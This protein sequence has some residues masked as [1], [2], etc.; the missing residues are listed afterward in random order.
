MIPE[1]RRS[2]VKLAVCAAVLGSIALVTRTA[3]AS[4][5]TPSVAESATPHLTEGVVELHGTPSDI[6]LALTD[7]RSW[8]QLF[9]DVA[10]VSVKSGG[11]E[12]AVVEIESRAFGHAHSFRFR[13][14]AVQ[15][16][17]FE[18][19][20]AHGL[21][22]WGEFFLERTSEKTTRVRARLYAEATGVVGFFTSEKSLREK[23]RSRMTSDLSSLARRWSG[24]S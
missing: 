24:S 1:A 4:H 12:N 16:L 3:Q 5:S 22:I 13:N 10:R 19:V 21:T 8:P 18:A 9:A 2:R 14:D 17:R 6:Y 20:D 15:R 7:Y 23:R 11:R